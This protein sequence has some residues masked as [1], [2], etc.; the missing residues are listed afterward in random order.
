MEPRL[1]AVCDLMVPN[2]RENAGLHVYD[3]LVQDLSPAGVRAGLARLGVGRPD[4]DPDDHDEAHLRA[5]EDLVRVGFTV[6]EE[7]RTNPYVHV[8]NLDLAVYDREYA[9][10][11]E[12][13]EARRRHLRGWPDAVEGALTS[14]DRMAAP[15]AAALAP[16]TAALAAGLRSDDP[17]EGPALAAVE[18][19]VAHVRTAA[20][21]GDPD[22][23][24]GADVLAELLGTGEAMEV[25][26][27]TLAAEAE[28]ER[29]RLEAMLEEACGRIDADRPVA[30]VIDGLLRDHPD[31]GGVIDEARDQVD[32]ALAFTLAHDLVPGLDGECLVGPTPPSR[33]WAFAMMAWAGPYEPDAPSWYHI[34]PPDPAWPPEQQEEWLEAFNRTTLPAITVHEVAPGHFAHGRA[35]RRAGT[36]VRRTL[37][38]LVFVEGWAHYVEE[39]CAEEGFRVDDPRFAAGVAIEALVRVTRLAVS[40][41]VHSREMSVDE[42]ARRFETDAY[43]KGPAARAEANRATFDPTYGRYTWGKLEILHLREQARRAWG[44]DYSHQRFHAELLALGAPPLGLMAS[45]LGLPS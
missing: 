19:L 39:L 3:G 1:R 33:R 31:A 12:R 35:L 6:V 28:R 13:T 2:V 20:E 44:P 30:D 5:F 40:I 41:G 11:A 45:G 32:E 36:D 43:L 7:H 38:S 27:G 10:A 26:L 37:M 23:S 21:R 17:V 34:T 18:R 15:T 24:L 9:P 8:D 22:A 29:E 14:L 16:A 4:G 25:D 42:A